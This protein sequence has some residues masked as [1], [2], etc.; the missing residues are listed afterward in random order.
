M[1]YDLHTEL[2]VKDLLQHPD[3]CVSKAHYDLR[4][5]SERDERSRNQKSEAKKEDEHPL[6]GFRF[7]L[8][9][10]N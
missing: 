5:H 8:D 2:Y 10:T 1:V 9:K 4:K 6:Q 3:P 7:T